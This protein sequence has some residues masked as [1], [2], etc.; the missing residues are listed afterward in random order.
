MNGQH[1]K[2][3]RRTRHARTCAGHL[4]GR[5]TSAIPTLGTQARFIQGPFTSNTNRQRKGRHVNGLRRHPRRARRCRTYILPRGRHSRHTRR[6][7]H[8]RP[9]NA[10]T[11]EGAYTIKRHKSRKRHR[12]K[13]RRTG[14]R[15]RNRERRRIDNSKRQATNK[16]VSN[17]QCNEDN[18]MTRRAD[19][20]IKR[21]SNV[22]YCPE[23]TSRGKDNRRP[24]IR[25]KC[26]THNKSLAVNNSRQVTRVRVYEQR[27]EH[28]NVRT[29]HNDNDDQQANNH[30]ARNL[31]L[32]LVNK[33]LK[34]TAAI[35]SNRSNCN[36]LIFK[37][38]N[39]IRVQ[40]IIGAQTR[41][42]FRRIT[43]LSLLSSPTKNANR[44]QLDVAHGPTAY[45][46]TQTR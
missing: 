16:Q 39:L 37:T 35:L 24:P 27:V 6:T 40:T 7:A 34:Q 22:R 38:R 13:N 1:R 5:R 3:R 4:T 33:Y 36:Y 12:R 19:R 26:L 15:R 42:Q 29:N 43:T 14:S 45:G 17:S 25:A 18:I 20:H 8:R 32:K 21:N 23:Y 11:R 31:N 9:Q 2:I 46:A 10:T 30:R 28:E 41:M 44:L